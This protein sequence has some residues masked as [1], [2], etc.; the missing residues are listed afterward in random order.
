MAEIDIKKLED[1]FSIKAFK[2]ELRTI[3]ERLQSSEQLGDAQQIIRLNIERANFFLDKAEQALAEG[4][5][6]ARLLE[7]AAKLLD[8]ITT[9][10]NSLIS[11]E[12]QEQEINQKGQLIDIKKLELEMKAEKTEKTE[13]KIQNQTN[14]ILVT[15]RES[16][17]RMLQGESQPEEPGESFVIEDADYNIITED[18]NSKIL[19]LETH[20][21]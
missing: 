8:T 20:I 10:A 3:E 7:V 19:Q 16:L 15:D 9:A 18:S 4:T 11:T 5:F 12:F 17:L 6:S 14:N 13:N 2:A 1:E 21:S